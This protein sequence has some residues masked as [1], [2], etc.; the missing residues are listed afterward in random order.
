[1]AKRAPEHF[2]TT[3]IRYRRAEMKSGMP[4]AE[5]LA[6]LSPKERRAYG[7]ARAKAEGNERRAKR[8]NRLWEKKMKTALKSR[9]TRKRR[10]SHARTR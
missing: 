7:K 8:Q 2:V 1:M 4:R 10:A 5:W 9:R 3:L 6:S